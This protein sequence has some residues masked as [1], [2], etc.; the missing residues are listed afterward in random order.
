MSFP[1]PTSIGTKARTNAAMNCPR[2]NNCF[3]SNCCSRNIAAPQDNSTIVDAHGENQPTKKCSGWKIFCCWPC[4]SGTKEGE[5]V[6]N[7]EVEGE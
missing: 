3:C 5:E 4:F 6:E 1:A 2:D 7:K